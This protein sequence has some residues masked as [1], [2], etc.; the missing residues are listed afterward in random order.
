MAK[1]D[2]RIAESMET[3]ETIGANAVTTED[4]L[5]II[6]N[7]RDKAARLLHQ[8]K[9]LFVTQLDGIHCL[10]RNQDFDAL[11]YLGGLSKAEAARILAAI[12]LGKRIANAS[13]LDTDHI[14]SP[15]SA[16]Q[17]LM[18]R[19]RNETHEKFVVVLLN[20]K[21]RVIRVK[22][23]AEGSLTSAVVHPREVFASAVNA[24]AACILVAHNHPS[25][26]PYPSTEDRNLTIALSQ[27]G[28]PQPDY[29]VG[30][31][32]EHFRHPPVG[33]R[34]NRGRKILQLQREGVTLTQKPAQRHWLIFII[35]FSEKERFYYG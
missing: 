27:C 6:L 17:L 31:G 5:A 19:L 22:Q 24:H 26:D 14:T 20:T 4:L 2:F 9:T 35:L 15:G 13:A 33:S 7:S 10:A 23:I 1:R 25:G 18:D 34:S 3:M 28:G 32:W 8:E 16:A 11:K 12:E 29:G 30:R 21:N